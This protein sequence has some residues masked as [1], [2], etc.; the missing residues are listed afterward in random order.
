[1]LSTFFTRNDSTFFTWNEQLIS[2]RAYISFKSSVDFVNLRVN[3]IVH[4]GNT[5]F[6]ESLKE[7]SYGT[8]MALEIM[9]PLL[10]QYFITW[11]TG[12]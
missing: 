9:G 2:F 8:K 7:E 10:N 4:A 12:S 6:V 5:V 1:M 3:F 11:I